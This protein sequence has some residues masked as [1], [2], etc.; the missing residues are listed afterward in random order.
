MTTG[1]MMMAASG[2][3]QAD[4]LGKVFVCKYV[5]QPGVDETL[6]T[7]DNPISV[8]INAIK[9]YQ[10]V[11]SYFN[12]AHD[13][14]FVLA[15]DTG[16]AEPD[17]SQCPT[18][19]TPT[20]VTPQISVTDPCGTAND[21]VTGVSK[22]G[23]TFVVNGSTVTFTAAAGYVLSGASTLTATFT[24][25]ACPTTPPVTG[26]PGPVDVCPNITGNQ[27]TVPKG[28][29]KDSSGDCVAPEVAGTETASPKPTKTPHEKP[30]V[31][32]TEAVP[33]A[34]DAGLPGPTAT[35]SSPVDLMAMSLVVGGFALLMSAGWMQIG[36]RTRGVH[37]V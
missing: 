24:D 29:T 36:R 34:V 26:G 30:T 18:P 7:G 23:Y 1:F 11:G 3:A 13:R 14:S 37:Q 15:L 5:G 31:K 32:G 33:T 12:D 35:A 2:P 16:Q 22:A 10:G 9:D 25:E 4:P 17:P 27:P 21:S 19:T 28:M 8:S 20:P 6:Q